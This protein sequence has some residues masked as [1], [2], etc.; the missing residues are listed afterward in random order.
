VI[1]EL[2]NCL[3]NTYGV[4]EVWGIPYGYLGFYSRDWIL[5]TPKMVGNIHHLGGTVLGS[6]RG[7]F[8]RK[9]IVDALVE[10]NISQVYAIGGDGTHRGA[11]EIFAEISERKLKIAIGCVPK[12]IDNDF[13]LIDHSF[14]FYTA[15]EEAQKAI[16]SAKVKRIC[17][18][19]P[20]PRKHFYLRH[21]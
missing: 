11:Q 12:T 14:G 13:Q 4:S 21:P 8:D 15:V 3:Y 18:N 10:K 16:Q 5:Y 2:V 1:R 7:G 19:F 17:L 9:K 20:H 6:S